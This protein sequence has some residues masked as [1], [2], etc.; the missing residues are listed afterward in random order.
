MFVPVLASVRVLVVMTAVLVLSVMLVIPCVAVER[1]DGILTDDETAIIIGIIVLAH[2]PSAVVTGIFHGNDLI[3]GI[4]GIV[5]AD[6]VWTVDLGDPVDGVVLIGGAFPIPSDDLGQVVV[7]IVAVMDAGFVGI[8][9]ALQLIGTV[10]SVGDGLSGSV[11]HLGNAAEAVILV[12]TFPGKI[13]HGYPLAQSVVAVKHAF[14]CLFILSGGRFPVFPHNHRV[15]C[16]FVGL[17]RQVIQLVVVVSDGVAAVGRITGQTSS[18]VIAP[19]L[20]PALRVC[21][22]GAVALQIVGISGDAAHGVFHSRHI[23]HLIVGVL[24]LQAAGQRY[25]C[26][27][28]QDIIGKPGI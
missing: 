10:I 2:D 12:S 9:D 16:I 21:Q 25:L 4:V 3:S 26:Q 17:L 15:F 24:G 18:R 22:A 8:G 13:H 23:A 20:R 6:A 7:L 11:C 19:F 27:I 1:F 5:G 14:F 28:I